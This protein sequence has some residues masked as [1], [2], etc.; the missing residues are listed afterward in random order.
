M[1]ALGHAF[2]DRAL[3]QQV[4][5]PE[6]VSFPGERE[7]LEEMLGNLLENA[8]RHAA[9]MV[10]FEAA[11]EGGAL[12]L[13]VEDDGPGF[14]DDTTAGAQGNGLGLPITREIAALYGGVLEVSRA[15]AGGARVTLR[16]P[17]RGPS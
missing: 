4:T 2:R 5:A 11:V 13:G 10:R 3:D 14:S 9:T 16:F 15:A 1:F 6:G 8:H 7:D 17:A 12:V